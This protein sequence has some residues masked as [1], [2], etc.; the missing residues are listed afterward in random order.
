[1]TKNLSVIVDPVPSENYPTT[2][3]VESTPIPDINDDEVLI[4]MQKV[5][6]CGS[7]VHY[8]THGKIGDFVVK[9]PMILGHEAAGKIEKVGKN[10]THLKIG[11]R[12][13]IEPGYPVENDEFSKTGRY[14]LSPVFFCAT[15]PDDGCLSN[16]YKHKADYC[17][18]LPDNMTYEEGAFCEPLSVGIHACRRGNVTLGC[19]VLILGAG[20]IGLVNVLVAKSMGAANIVVVDINEDRLKLAEKIGA[21]GVYVPSK[22]MKPRDQAVKLINQLFDGREPSVCIECTGVESCLQLAVFSCKR[23]GTVVAVGMSKEEVNFPI[24]LLVSKKRIESYI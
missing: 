15:P 8:W 21:N 1:M 14:N 9:K 4:S 20:P 6:I 5:G 23:A 18:K 19:D 11:D 13:A 3:K 12:V 10:V 16:F 17:Y 22:E 24:L 7:D 2:F